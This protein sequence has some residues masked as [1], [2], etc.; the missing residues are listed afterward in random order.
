MRWSSLPP[1]LLAHVLAHL[2][3]PRLRLLKAVSRATAQTCR[4]VL[5]SPEWCKGTNRFEVEEE[6]K[7]QSHSYK[8]PMTVSLFHDDFEDGHKCI[9]TVH[10]LKLLRMN[11]NGGYQN[12]RGGAREWEHVGRHNNDPTTT[13]VGEMCI[14]IHGEGVVGSEYA[15][16]NMLQEV[17]RQRCCGDACARRTAAELN[18]SRIVWSCSW[19]GRESCDK[20]IRPASDAT[21]P[22]MSLH[23]LLE[24]ICP[25]TQ[26]AQGVWAVHQMPCS[27]QGDGE[28]EHCVMNVI[29]MC[30]MGL[31]LFV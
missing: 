18:T 5:R 26:I 20:K 13:I 17:M 28:Y 31:D 2:T 30:R 8:L 3:L 11:D 25:A 23:D 21:R 12:T 9:A 4:S 15:L 24:E 14:E 16:R 1:E 19:S 7:T 6:L 29:E 10:R 27:M 22:E